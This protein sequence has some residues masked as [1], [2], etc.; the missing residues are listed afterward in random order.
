M[1]CC[2]HSLTALKAVVT[3]RASIHDLVY[4]ECSSRHKLSHIASHTTTLVKALVELMECLCGIALV[5]C[6]RLILGTQVIFA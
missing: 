4:I 1:L 2:K 3:V 5:P 6:T